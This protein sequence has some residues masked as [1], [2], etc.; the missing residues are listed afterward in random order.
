MFNID[1]IVS[2]FD[3]TNI[4]ESLL[5][6]QQQQ[7]DSL[8]GRKA[9]ITTEQSSFKGI[10]AQLLTLR[11][12]LSQLN[13]SVNSVFDG[14]V[15]TSSNEE[16]LTATAGSRAI[17]GS[18]RLSVDQLAAAH[19]IASQGFASDADEIA[20]GDISFKVGNR[21]EQTI[22]IDANNNTLEGFVEAVNEQ[23][24]DVS[25]SLV[26]DQGSGSSRILLTSRFTGASNTIAVTSSQDPLTGVLPDFDGPAVQP[27]LNAIVTLGSGVGAISAEYESNTVDGLIDNVTLQLNKADVGNPLTID[28]EPDTEAAE[29][30]VAGF[31]ENF[32]SIIDFIDNATRFDPVTETASPL[33]GNRS[34]TSIKNELLTIVSGTVADSPIGRLAEIGIDLNLQGKLALDTNKLSEALRGELEDVDADDIRSLFGL[35]GSSDNSGIRFLGGS[36]RTQAPSSP[37]EVNITQAAER[38]EITASNALADSIIID[39]ANR[40]FTVSVN[41]L[42]SETLSLTEGTYTRAELAEQLQAAINGSSELRNNRVNVTVDTSNQLVIQTEGYGISAKLS[43]LSGSAAATLG[44]DGSEA[45]SGQDVAGTFTVDGVTEEADGTGRVLSG[46]ADNE[47]T[48][49]LRVEVTLTDSQVVAGSEANLTVTQGITGQLSSYLSEILDTENGLIKTVDDSFTSRIA[50]ID[51]SIEQVEEIT[52]LR[53]QSLIEEFAALESILNELQ[54]TGNFL[55][56]QFASLSSFSTGNNRN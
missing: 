25:A 41:G 40:E 39:S 47:F 38:A 17:A 18:Y 6:F 13:R 22:T 37:I 33:L 30:A 8:N 43:E 2:G 23:V 48:A 56:S 16:V 9:E 42:D 24:D 45:D 15:A 35:N 27:A 12:S 50:D 7:V 28:I 32:N 10:E 34:V 49:D 29:E 53:R 1:G 20:T 44:F 46:D 14:R 31:V 36:Q 52:E 4:I 26:F 19:Q 55:A 54:S 5:G 21:A 51:D 3:T 11:G